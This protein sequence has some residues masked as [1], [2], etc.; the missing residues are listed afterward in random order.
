MTLIIIGMPACGKSCMG[1]A[2]ARKLRMKCV[3]ADRVIERVTD[4]KLQD[5][6]NEDGIDA[7]MEIER[8]V[9]KTLSGDNLIISTGGSAVYYPEVMEYFKSIGKILYLY[10]SLDV[11]K[12]R[13]G[14]FSKRG[15][16]LK[17]GQTLEDLYDE[18]CALYEKYADITVDCSGN[19]YPKYQ[20]RV[21]QSLKYLMDY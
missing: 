4:R 14:D 20:S 13:L 3:D 11:I 10:C 6:I 5:I 9:L 18:R 16:I 2:L 21:I 7:F 15:V 17:D 1:R 8:T 19:A 12:T